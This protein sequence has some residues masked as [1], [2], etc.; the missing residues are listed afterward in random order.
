ME[1][2]GHLHVLPGQLG[3]THVLA[4]NQDYELVAGTV[5]GRPVRPD[6]WKK[7]DNCYFVIP[8]CRVY[9]PPH[10]HIHTRTRPS[11]CLSVYILCHITLCP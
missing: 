2:M 9:V 10:T 4:I 3:I 11:V 7:V 5:A 1:S 8:V 6:A